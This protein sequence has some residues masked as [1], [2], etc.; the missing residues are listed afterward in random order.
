MRVP[1]RCRSPLTLGWLGLLMVLS[2]AGFPVGTEQSQQTAPPGKLVD[3]GGYRLHLH[4]LGE[5]SPAF[6]L[7]YGGGGR[8]TD[9]HLVQPA[10]AQFTRAC[11]YDR[12]GDG[13]SE[14]GPLPR[15]MRQNAY[16]LHTLLQKAGV[17]GPYV[18]A[19][20]SYSEATRCSM[21]RLPPVKGSWQT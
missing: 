15:T 8:A 2:L 11:A 12:A 1:N 16:E 10:V 3:I 21:R 5:G 7:L 4:C 18:L 13:W 19:G 9:F 20:Q 17:N 14:S 6:V